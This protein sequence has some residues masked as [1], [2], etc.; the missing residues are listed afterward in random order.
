MAIKTNTSSA[1][2]LVLVLLPFLLIGSLFSSCEQSFDESNDLSSETNTI[3]TVIETDSDAET[4]SLITYT[5]EEL[6]VM[7]FERIGLTHEE[8]VDA[9]KIFKNVG[10]SQIWDV[11]ETIQGSGIDGEQDFICNFYDFNVQTD[12]IRLQFVIVKRKVQIIAISWGRG[13]NY[14]EINKYDDLKLL[15][16][17]KESDYGSYVYLYRKKLK[18]FAVDEN[19]VGYRAVYNRETHS[20][21]KYK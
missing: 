21:S 2:M 9:Q 10:I 6:M 7:Q 20:I 5:D 12:S 14:P 8:A 13:K 16:G 19:S 18:N 11:S 4:S 17:V 3:S 1:F 15:D